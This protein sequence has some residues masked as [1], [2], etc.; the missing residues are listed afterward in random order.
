MN[1]GSDAFVTAR[2]IGLARHIGDCTSALLRVPRYRGLPAGKPELRAY[3][4]SA[5]TFPAADFFFPDNLHRFALEGAVKGGSAAGEYKGARRGE[6]RLGLGSGARSISVVTGGAT[7]GY[8]HQRC[9]RQQAVG[10]KNE[11]LS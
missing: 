10:R 8:A 7:D 9:R 5:L 3:S 4:V 11:L 1:L 2:G 6:E